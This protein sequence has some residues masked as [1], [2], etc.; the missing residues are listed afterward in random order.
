M[1]G[2]SHQHVTLDTFGIFKSQNVSYE[3]KSKIIWV[4]V[5]NHSWFYYL[6]AYH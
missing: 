5:G 2:E 1:W 4:K 6:Q 3:N